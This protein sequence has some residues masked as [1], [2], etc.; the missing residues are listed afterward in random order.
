MRFVSVMY[1]SS[2]FPVG[3][4]ED[5]EW[6]EMSDKYGGPAYLDKHQKKQVGCFACPMRSQELPARAGVRQGLH[7]L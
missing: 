3:Y 5:V 7:Y 1:K 4:F 2:F 6:E